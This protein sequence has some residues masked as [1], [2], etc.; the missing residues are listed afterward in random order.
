MVG[1]KGEFM[2]VILTVVSF[3]IANAGIITRTVTHVETMI[4]GTSE[5]KK[6]A[7]MRMVREILTQRGIAWTMERQALVSAAIDIIVSG[8]NYV[9]GK[10]W[11]KKT[12]Q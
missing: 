3:L 8:Y 10:K 7:A 11:L 12:A 2:K 1:S 6:A 4:K 9:S 5:E